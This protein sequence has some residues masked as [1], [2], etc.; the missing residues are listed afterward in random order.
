MK[1]KHKSPYV[2]MVLNLSH[3]VN[4][5]AKKDNPTPSEVNAMVEV[6]KLLFKTI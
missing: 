2:K 6:S 3:F 1:N 5:T 4:R